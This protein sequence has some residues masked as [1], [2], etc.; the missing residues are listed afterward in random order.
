MAKPLQVKESIVYQMEHNMRGEA[1][2]LQVAEPFVAPF[3]AALD[4]RL[5]IMDAAVVA[6]VGRQL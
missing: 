6:G 2:R 3:L 1:F 4:H 5:G